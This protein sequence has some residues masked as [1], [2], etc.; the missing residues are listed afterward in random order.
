M[1]RSFAMLFGAAIC[2][3]AISAPAHASLNDQFVC[4]TGDERQI[5]VTILVTEP[6]KAML[7]QRIDD[8]SPEEQTSLAGAAPGRAFRF[9]NDKVRFMGTG[10]IGFLYSEGEQFLCRLPGEPGA[11][12]EYPSD[13]SLPSV[14]VDGEGLF[15]RVYD[16]GQDVRWNFGTP[17][18]D[19]I[20]YLSRYL[21]TPGPV[22]RNEE[23]G[24]GPMEFRQMGELQLNFQ[25]NKFVGW[26]LRGIEGAEKSVGISLADGTRPGD[27]ALMITDRLEAIEGSTLGS[28]YFGSGITALID[29]DTDTVD[30]L[31]GGTNCV[32]R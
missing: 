8:T 24:A 17:R 29:E 22:S 15:V 13:P 4:E 2:V 23:C 7:S 32:F 18:A 11:D 31:M 1:L 16:I 10:A 12:V 30:L 5:N 14:M 9:D 3:A 19:I 6:G 26:S 21:G 25:A 20:S 28:E 27:P